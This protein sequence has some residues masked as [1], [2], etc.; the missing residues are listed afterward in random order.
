M[1]KVDVPKTN[2][3]WTTTCEWYIVY[4]GVN[5]NMDTKK[6]CVLERLDYVLS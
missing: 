2:I 4:V 3:T 6:T 1:F 5:L